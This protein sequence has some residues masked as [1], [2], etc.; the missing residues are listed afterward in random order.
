MTQYATEELTDRS[1]PSPATRRAGGGSHRRADN[2]RHRARSRSA[3]K[4]LLAV[5]AV[6]ATAT[7]AVLGGKALFSPSSQDGRAAAAPEPPLPTSDTP[8]SAPPTSAAPTGAATAGTTPAGTAPGTPSQ[9]AARLTAPAPQSTGPTRLPGVSA[10]T[11]PVQRSGTAVASPSSPPAVPSPT[12]AAPSATIDSGSGTDLDAAANQVLVLINQARAAQGVAPLQILAG[13][14]TSANAHNRTMAA[15]CGL[16]HQCPGEAAFGDREHA[17]GVQ[18]GTAGENI[19]DGGPTDDTTDAMAAMAVGLT[20][21]MLA[22]QPPNDGHRRNILNP[23]FH[24]IGIELL[25]DSSGTVWMTQ[26]F[27]D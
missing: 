14:Q 26:D 20:N 2:G 15:G 18:W 9:S 13:L 24:H 17:G 7:T 19:G 4:P 3:A 25:R 8:T 16:Q 6:A 27:S 23:A 11:I 21:D 5:V 10:G 12:Q 1:V 22:E